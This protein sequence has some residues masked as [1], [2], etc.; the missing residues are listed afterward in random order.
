MFTDVNGVILTYGFCVKSFDLIHTSRFVLKREILI[1][2]YVL[3]VFHQEVDQVHV[4]PGG[5]FWFA[6]HLV[7]FL[8]R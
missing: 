2:I 1:N 4:F 5:S 6:V 7:C 3:L 8:S